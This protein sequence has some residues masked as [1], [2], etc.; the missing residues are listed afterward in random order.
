MVHLY[1]MPPSLRTRAAILPDV[2][3]IHA[4]IE[5]YAHQNTQ[6]LLPRSVPELC[7]NVRDFIV[8][9][10]NGRIVGC[11]ALHLYG[12]HLAEIRSIAVSPQSKGLGVGR[13]MVAALLEESHRQ[14]VT[15]VCLFTRTPEFFG[16]L[17]FQ[18]AQ[19]EMLPDKIYKDC[20]TCP[21][22]ND[23]DEIAMVIGA[24]PTNSNGLR[25][26]LISIP[27]IKPKL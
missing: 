8:A 2:E 26:P 20:I 3:H 9:E 19:R 23:C 12:M 24:I 22:L 11:G 14:A 15:C 16:H 10:D 5:P 21:R 17:G 4:I 27:S 6:V 7:E 13:A 18:V 25:D 1:Y